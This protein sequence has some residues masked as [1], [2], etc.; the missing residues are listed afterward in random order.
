MNRQD[1]F[2]LKLQGRYR[3]LEVFEDRIRLTP[4]KVM[5]AFFNKSKIDLEISLGRLRAVEFHR[6]TF[7]SNT[8]FLL[9]VSDGESAAADDFLAYETD[10]RAL[11]FDISD[12]RLAKRICDSL[13][14]RMQAQS[15]TWLSASNDLKKWESQLS[16]E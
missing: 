6:C 10:P 14:E 5:G 9:F 15:G 8:G 13:H 16:G 11:T 3:T 12:I 7:A 1:P 2:N 4:Q